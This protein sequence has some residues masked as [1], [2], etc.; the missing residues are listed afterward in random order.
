VAEADDQSTVPDMKRQGPAEEPS[1]MVSMTF[2]NE[3]ATALSIAA[4]ALGG[5]VY[6]LL[7][8]LAE[9]VY[10]PS[11]VTSSEVGLGYGPCFLGRP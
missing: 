8:L 10:E 2:V 1:G 4:A 3:N 6:V 9:W 5:V 7:T 11:G